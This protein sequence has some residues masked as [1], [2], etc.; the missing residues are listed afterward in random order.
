MLPPSSL[1]DPTPSRGPNSLWIRA[2][3]TKQ[4]LSR[5]SKRWHSVLL[6]FIYEEVSFRHATQVRAFA[7]SLRENA[8]LSIL[9]KKIVVDCP[10]TSEIQ[11]AVTGDLAYILT[12]C[13]TL[14]TL[15]FTDNLFGMEDSLRR[16]VLYPF[17]PTLSAA[18]ETL[19]GTLQRFEQWPQGGSPHFT[20]PI[21]CILHCALTVLAINVDHPASLE[22]ITLPA[23]EELDLSQEYDV[24]GG[25]GD[26]SKRF[27]GWTLPCLKRL[28]L[29]VATDM[30]GPVLQR[31][32]KSLEY[33]EFRDH[34]DM[35]LQ[36]HI[37]VSL[38]TE[39][40]RYPHLEHIQNCT[41]LRHLVFQAKDSNDFHVVNQLPAH[42]TLA[43]IDIWA[44]SPAGACRLDFTV[45]RR[46]RKLATG[47]PWKNIRLL[48]RALSHIPLLP[49]LFPPDTPESELPCTHRI[50][51]LAIIHAPWGL[52]RGD[53]DALCSYGQVAANEE[54]S[55]GSH[56]SDESGDINTDTSDET[57]TEDEVSSD[58]SETESEG[59]E[60]ME[61]DP[62]VLI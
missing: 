1:L 28:I 44:S 57:Y 9:V 21:S 22:K 29:P 27:L 59:E 32:G 15:V 18:I 14:R 61:A 5:V 36:E 11:D 17:P 51:G 4:Q 2:L 53:L 60:S 62:P 41:Q 35:G 33:L 52:Y 8:N 23:L 47:I 31:Y 46:T 34:L 12:R 38:P 50:P 39:S 26:H 37:D 40:V 7:R 55:S 42:P 16:V 20:F 56:D 24:R 54:S 58:E 30:Q 25:L 13:T 45:L 3:T 49:R 19:S 43:Y 10:V 6:S 48:D